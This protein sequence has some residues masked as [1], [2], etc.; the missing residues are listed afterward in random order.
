MPQ[1][2]P[3]DISGAGGFLY[4]KTWALQRTFNWQV[5]LPHDIAGISGFFVSQYCQD[6]RFRDYSFAEASTMRYGPKRR[7][8]AGM[9]EIESF[10]LV[11]IYPVDTSVAKYFVK[12]RER[13]IDKD[14]YYHPKND[15]ARDVY[16]HL[17]D[18]SD[19]QSAQFRLRGCWPKTSPPYGLSYAD[20]NVLRLEVV[21]SV[22]KIESS[23]LIGSILEGVTNFAGS[24]IEKGKDLFGKIT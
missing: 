7:F 20:E 18:R 24:A 14:G 23:S 22:D 10:T 17:Y 19:I 3:F 1:R 5:F 12:W 6:V 21:L 15:Y 11:F 16:I 4:R 9:E 13:V 2:L 8:Y